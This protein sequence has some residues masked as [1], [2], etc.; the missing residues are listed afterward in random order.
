MPAAAFV[1]II[2]ILGAKAK[3]KPQRFD[4][5]AARK[6]TLN[7]GAMASLQP[8]PTFPQNPYLIPNCR[9]RCVPPFVVIR[10]NCD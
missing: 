4:F 6:L 9:M 2:Q 3:P 1:L 5:R 7:A 8:Q 10:P